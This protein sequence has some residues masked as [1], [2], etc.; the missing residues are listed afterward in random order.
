MQRERR[1]RESQVTRHGD[2]PLATEALSIPVHGS[3]HPV[4]RAHANVNRGI[5]RV[6]N[7]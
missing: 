7:R 1:K 5:G 3:D 2:S 4:L 6:R